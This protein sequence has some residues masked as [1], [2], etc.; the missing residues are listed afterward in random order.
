VYFPL[1]QEPDNIFLEGIG[2]Q[3]DNIV[4][5]EFEELKRRPRNMEDFLQG[6]IPAEK[7]DEFKKSFDIMGDV[8]ILEIPE[9][10]EEEKYLIG[11]AALKFTKRRSVYRKK[12]PL[13]VLSEPG[14][15][16]TLRVRIILKPST[17]NM[18]PG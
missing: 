5:A 3:M 11:D 15:W 8:V 7:M 6:K 10:L 17:G 9:D 13:R 1:N 18:I 2:L 14:N 16:N 4:E 12:V